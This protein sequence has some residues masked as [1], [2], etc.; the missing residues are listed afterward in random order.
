MLDISIDKNHNRIHHSGEPARVAVE[1]AATIGAIYNGYKIVDEKD[2]AIFRL[3][4][5]TML[6]PDSGVWTPGNGDLTTVI[7]P[8]DI[9]KGGA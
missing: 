5:E 9:K 7:I 2:A 3:A 1:I 6:R 8:G 4:V